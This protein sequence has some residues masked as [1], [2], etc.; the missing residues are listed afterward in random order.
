MKQIVRLGNP[1]KQNV[2]SGRFSAS[3][4]LR[5][6]KIRR[7]NTTP[8][9]NNPPFQTGANLKCSKRNRRSLAAG[10]AGG[11]EE[12]GL[13]VGGVWGERHRVWVP[14]SAWQSARGERTRPERL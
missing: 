13:C 3:N 1:M 10:R 6:N 9:I 11:R 8:R 4:A 7:I 2:S 5:I 14:W 12:K